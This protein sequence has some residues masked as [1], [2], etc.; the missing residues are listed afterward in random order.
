[1]HHYTRKRV[2]IILYFWFTKI[3]FD[4]ETTFEGVIVADGE[5]EIKFWGVFTGLVFVAWGGG[6]RI[7]VGVVCLEIWFWGV[8]T[9]L[10]ARSVTTYSKQ[11]K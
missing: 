3:L 4:F 2:I 9:C 10:R 11:L 6:D 8:G 5:R 1:M 7:T